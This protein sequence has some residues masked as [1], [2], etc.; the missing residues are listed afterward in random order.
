MHADAV[1]VVA[2]RQWTM[3]T[4]CL[5]PERGVQRDGELEFLRCRIAMGV[6]IE[7]QPDGG[8][9]R[10]LIAA[11]QKGAG[12]GRGRPVNMAKVVARC[13][14]AQLVEIQVI[15]CRVAARP[16]LKIMRDA[17]GQGACSENPR[18]HMHVDRRRQRDAASS[19]SQRV[20][21]CRDQWADG[22]H[23]AS[24]GWDR[25]REIVRAGRCDGANVDSTRVV[26]DPERAVGGRCRRMTPFGDDAGGDAN[27]VAHIDAC[28]AHV[29]CGG[30][31]RGTRR[32]NRRACHYAESS[33]S[34][35]E[36]LPP[37]K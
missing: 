27:G 18:M 26:P 15:A 33:E 16:S 22:D 5:H 4:Q 30:E 31:V 13:I 19:Q 20:A 24:I 12:F 17:D 6:E 36:Q 23:G 1:G 25:Q 37:A 32:H 29:K 34:G 3:L 14:V 8:M 28:A 2:C 9:L 21:G 11:N 10:S 7:Q 35:R